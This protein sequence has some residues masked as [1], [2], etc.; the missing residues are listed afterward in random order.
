MPRS[1]CLPWASIPKQQRSF[2]Q[3]DVP[4]SQRTVLAA[5]DRHAD[6]PSRKVPRLQGQEGSG[7]TADAGLFTYPVLMAADILIYDSRP[8]CRSASTRCSTSKSAATSPRKFN[9][10]FKQEVFVHLPKANVLEASAKVPGIDGEK[11]SKSYNNTIEIFEPSAAMRKKVM[12]IKT[13]LR[14]MEEP[15]D[16]VGDHLFD[17]YR[18]FAT[19]D[20]IA[21]MDALYRRGGFGYGEVKKALAEAADR[22]F[23]PARAK[24]EELAADLP[25]VR[26]ILADGARRA[27]KKA[28]ETLRRAK[29]ACGIG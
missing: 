9:Y 26:D 5:D 21:A 10:H 11:M 3:S 15:K 29:D 6:G 4:E 8:L 23:A 12:R 25:K 20:E 24:R 17:L 2:V 1:I 19:A 28:S 13:D 18:L 16:P 22:Y 7:L 14:P 27:R